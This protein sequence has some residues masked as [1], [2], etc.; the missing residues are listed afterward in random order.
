MEDGE[1]ATF[2]F[3][4]PPALA[5]KTLRAIV[6]YVRQDGYLTRSIDAALTVRTRD[7]RDVVLRRR[8]DVPITGTSVLFE[9]PATGIADV[10]G[11]QLG[12]DAPVVIL[13]QRR[14]DGNGL[15]PAAIWV[16]P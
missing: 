7:G 11:L 14:S 6:L 2:R 15:E 1:T 9:A 4:P 16:G 3:D 10:S 12:T 5:G 8:V 13:G